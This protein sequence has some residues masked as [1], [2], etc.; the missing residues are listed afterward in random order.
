MPFPSC[1]LVYPNIPPRP[2]PARGQEGGRALCSGSRLSLGPAPFPRCGT[3]SMGAGAQ[4]VLS[5][6]EAG[7]EPGA[8]RGPSGRLLGH[9]RRRCH[10]HHPAAGPQP[11][12]QAARP[13]PGEPGVCLQGLRAGG[14]G[15]DLCRKGHLKPWAPRGS[16][17]GAVWPLGASRLCLCP[18]LGPPFHQPRTDSDHGGPHCVRKK[19]KGPRQGWALGTPP[20]VS[21]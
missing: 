7:T 18:H 3:W 19:T 21:G 13:P 12:D 14:G 17:Q 1:F 20:R 8:A 15:L 11:P 9:G 2:C 10:G 16:E 6:G 4:T 5:H